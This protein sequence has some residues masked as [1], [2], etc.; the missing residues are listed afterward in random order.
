[1]TIQRLVAWAAALAALLA[2]LFAA[3]R[4]HGQEGD[5][6]RGY[7]LIDPQNKGFVT[8][9]E[10][11]AVFPDQQKATADFQGMDA[12]KDQVVTKEEFL[13]VKPAYKK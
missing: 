4:A 12:N 8:L 13:A 7:D 5:D 3:P 6:L 10:Y 9:P 11:L 1:M 2:I